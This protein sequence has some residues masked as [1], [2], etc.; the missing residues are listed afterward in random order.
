M[1][2]VVEPDALDAG[3]LAGA[4]PGCAPF[5]VGD[6]AAVLAPEE[7]PVGS[8]LGVVAQVR[9]H[10]LDHRRGKADAAD[11]GLGLRRA[12]VLGSLARVDDAAGHLHQTPL[13]VDVLAAEFPDLSGA[14][15]TPSS[16]QH[17]ELPFVGH[18]VGDLLNRTGG[19]RIDTAAAGRLAG[20][21]HPDRADLEDAVVDRGQANRAQELVGLIAAAPPL[22]QGQRPPPVLHL[23]SVEVGDRHV[24]E[25]VGRPDLRTRSLAGAEIGA[26]AECER[27][28]ADVDPQARL[29]PGP[30]CLTDV[31]RGQPLASVAGYRGTVGCGLHLSVA[32]GLALGGRRPL[33]GLDQAPFGRQPDP[34]VALG[35]EGHRRDV[36]RAGGD[37]KDAAV[38]VAR[39]EVA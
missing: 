27:L 17:T 1:A 39:L 11:T 2:E 30:C 24:T 28:A 16:Q 31:S 33:P 14:Q 23:G 3:G 7:Q 22:G 12:D 4:E 38:P 37:T 13:E 18:G 32:C 34:G 19:D 8:E 9:A 36:D 5:G 25:R 6:V 20:T 15:R 21:L 10:S 26:E 35:L 29:V